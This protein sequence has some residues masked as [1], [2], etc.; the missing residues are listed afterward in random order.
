MQIEVKELEPCKLLI[1]YE[2][3]AGQILD[4]RA[5]VLTH[6]KKAPVPGFRPGK[7]SVE[8]IKLHYRTQIEE[9][10]KRALVE[11]AY[12]NTLFEKKMKPHGAPK[13]NSAM[14]VGGKF[15]CEFEMLTKPEFTLADYKGVEV[16]RPPYPHSILELTE[17]I[18]QELRMRFSVAEPFAEDDFVQRGNNVIIDYEGSVDGVKNDN[19]CSVGETLTVGASKLPNFDDN[20]LGMK[21]GETR[22]FSLVVP[23]GGLPSLAG[24]TVDFKVTLVIGSKVVPCPLDDSLAEKVGKTTFSEVREMAQGIANAKVQEGEHQL[25]TQAVSAKLVELNEISV[26]NWISLSEAQYLAHQSRLVWDKLEDNDKELYLKLAEKNT[27]LTLILDRI[28]DEEPEAQL[29]DQEVFE[30][31]RQKIVSSNPKEPVDDII[32]NM[33]QSGYTQILFSRI[34]DEYTLDFVTKTMKVITE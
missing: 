5:E 3:D 22:E 34:K 26:P 23:E 24:K 11:D 15:T 20:L 30:M 25:L 9:S 14:L 12:H 6:F 13:I 27:K 21:V 4:K 10:L 17:N 32:K 2:A 33:N 18:L 31:I 28:R 29:S 8:S 1:S 16:V 7:A 19:L